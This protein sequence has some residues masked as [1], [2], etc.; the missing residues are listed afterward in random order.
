MLLLTVFPRLGASGFS[1][2]ETISGVEN[3][4]AQSLVLLAQGIDDLKLID[5]RLPAD[6]YNG[7]I[8]DSIFLSD[9]DR[10]C[11]GLKSSDAAKQ[12][13]LV[14]Y[15]NGIHCARSA[16]AVQNAV[17]C[18]YTRVYWLRGGFDEWRRSDFPYLLE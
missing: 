16:R 14:F 5:T 12:Q 2:P 9:L 18:G 8:E 15:S 3:L 17:D 6:R 1:V 11:A 4:T 7:F 13:T 10:V